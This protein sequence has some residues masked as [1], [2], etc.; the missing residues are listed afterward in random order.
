M[1]RQA[2]TFFR[3]SRPVVAAAAVLSLL[4]TGMVTMAA[5][6]ADEG[7][8]PAATD[9]ALIASP[10]TERAAPL[11]PVGRFGPSDSDRSR[12]TKVAESVEKRSATSDE[13]LNSDGTRSITT[14]ALP[15]YYQAAGSEAWS[16]IDTVLVADETRTGWV[17]SNANRWT[18][19]FAAAGPEV[20]TQRVEVDG[21]AISFAPIGANEQAT[22]A[23]DG[24]AVTYDD[25]WRETDAV[26][27]VKPTGTDERLVLKSAD[28]PTSFAFAV[29]GATPRANEGGGVDLTVGR[30][31]IAAVPPLTVETSRGLVRASKAGAA[32]AVKAVGDN[33]GEITISISPDW[34]KDLPADAFPVV[35]DPSVEPVGYGTDWASANN[36][37]PPGTQ[38]S[39]LRVGN[40]FGTKWRAR[41]KIAVPDPSV[42][43][44]GGTQP[45]YLTRAHLHA[46]V[47]GFAYNEFQVYAHTSQPAT[48]FAA[49]AAGAPQTTYADLVGRHEA[50]V[51]DWV[52]LRPPGS[53]A[54]YGFKGNETFENTLETLSNPR[55]EYT[56]VQSPDPTWLVSPVG[57]ISTT[58][59]LLSADPRPHASTPFVDYDFKVT[60]DAFGSGTVVDSGWV[61]QPTWQVPAGALA[62]GITYYVTVRVGINDPWNPDGEHYVPPAAPTQTKTITVKQRL[63]AGG[64]TPTDTVG[65]VPGATQTPSKGAPSPGAAPASVTVNMVTGNLALSVNTHQLSTVSGPAGASLNYDSLGTT[66]LNGSQRGL[67]GRYSFNGAVIGQR[68]D[69][70]IDFNWPGSPMGGY[71]PSSSY[72]FSAEWIGNVTVPASG[73][74]RLGGSVVSGTMTVY[75]DGSPTPYVTLGAGATPTFGAATGWSPGSQHALR[76][77]YSTSGSRVGRLWARNTTPPS[78]TAADVVV[79]TDWLTP[80]VTGL[81][82]GWRLS[83]NPYSGSWTRIEDLGGQAV[84]QSSTG[85]TVTFTRRVDG[86]YQS[87]AGVHDSLTAAMATRPGQFSMGEFRL[88]TADNFL[89]TFG[90]DGWVRKVESITD[91]RKPAA[92]A[93]EYETQLGVVG[94]PVLKTITDPVTTRAITLCYGGEAA[95]DSSGSNAP[96]GMLG[97][98]T[99]WDGAAGSSY[100]TLVY[101]SGRLV[102]VINPGNLVADFGY[103][104][105]GRLNQIRDPLAN[106]VIAQGLISTCPSSN[107]GTD[108]ST[109][110]TYDS[111]A[112]VATVAQPAPHGFPVSTRPS[113]SYTY[114]TGLKRTSVSVAGFNPSLGY[115]S[116]AEYDG[117][118]R[119][120]KQW[121]AEGRL[122]ETKWDPNIDRP[123]T[124]IDAFGL[125]TTDI[126]GTANLLTDRWGPAPTSC[127]STTAPYAPNGSCTVAVTQHE[128]DE[129]ID[130]LAATFW[131]NPNQTGPAKLHLTGPG[132]TGPSGPGCPT[133][134]LCTQWNTPPVTPAGGACTGC[135]W[136]NDYFAWS[137]RLTGT[138]SVPANTQ[139]YVF[140]TQYVTVSSNGV[141]LANHD[142]ANHDDGY[143]TWGGSG[144][145]SP[146]LTGTIPIQIDFYGGATGINGFFIWANQGGNPWIPNQW[147]SPGYGLETTSIDPDN[148][149][150]TTSYTD[151]ATGIGPEFG[152][153]T[154]V[155]ADPN[156][157]ALTTRTTYE[158][159]GT[160]HWLRKTASTLPAGNATT[161]VNY[162]GKPGV[163]DCTGDQQAGAWATACGVTVGDAQHGL[164]AEQ[165]DPA[166]SGGQGRRQQFLYDKAGRAVGRRVGPANTIGARPWQCT[167]FD[168]R[169][170]PTS[171]TYPSADGA[172]ARTVTYGYAVGGDPRVAS[173]TDP[174]GTVTASVD[175]L[176]RVVDYTDVWGTY[177]AYYYDQAGRST[178]V[179]EPYGNMVNTYDPNTGRLTAVAASG[180]VANLAY[181]TN[182]LLNTVT[183]TAPGGHQSRLTAGY[184]ALFRQNSAT[185]ANLD[186]T[187]PARI[188]GQTVTYSL[189]GRKTN[190]TLE[191]GAANPIEPNASGDDFVYDGAGRV[192]TAH[193]VNGRFDYSYAINPGADGC[194]FSGGGANSNRTAV[195]FVPTSGTTTV[196]RSCYNTADQL[197]R[198]IDAAGPSTGYAYD[199]RGNQ[200]SNPGTAYD[201][202]AADRLASA[203]GNDMTAIYTRDALDRLVARN[204]T[205]DTVRYA[206]AGFTDTPAAILNTT[207]AVVERHLA[208]PGGV[209]T[210]TTPASGNTTWSFPDMAGNIVTTTTNSGTRSSGPATYDPWGAAHTGGI[211]NTATATK[212]A[213]FGT[214]GKLTDGE[215]GGHTII[216]M[217]ARPYNPTQARF[218]AVDPIAGGC[219][220]NYVYVYGDPINMSDLSGKF[221]IPSLSF[222]LGDLWDATGGKIVSAA[223]SAHKALCGNS[224]VRELTNYVGVAGKGH[225]SSLSNTAVKA[226]VTATTQGTIRFMNSLTKGIGFFESTPLLRAVT[227]VNIAS[228]AVATG[229]NLSCRAYD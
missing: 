6:A 220:N 145:P 24:S 64:P 95:C 94:A 173:V 187:G 14:Y 215:A 143:G 128:Y 92:L 76:V 121:D 100:S 52:A 38:S 16:P 84:L 50:D 17:H 31:M 36:A 122:T 51:T 26:Y 179:S 144:N 9:V 170:R 18:A 154:A 46:D 219:A 137:M 81:P 202:D 189:A 156:G 205:S 89:F 169:G 177:T 136:P 39:V 176:G 157:V 131:P 210:T 78:G 182:G 199:A 25:L 141:Q 54:W 66:G 70:S 58:T 151:T 229:F 167:T 198:T 113:R 159:P 147:L 104:A 190:A 15:R 73:T 12:V 214:A 60:T 212:H 163:T 139:L 44:P 129:G 3:R 56:F 20:G 196:T 110:V 194:G 135:Y 204:N 181:N 161:Y 209:R 90:A 45:W 65:S 172:P 59:P 117:Q 88:A 4:S 98:I 55:I 203:T 34:L 29:S 48:T 148:K 5:Q 227:K 115:A 158:T 30:K 99:Y 71:A 120:I 106:D 80:R 97:R 75:V 193:V 32:F 134:T 42:L 61:P 109:I 41:T 152:L 127:F 166:P 67:Y 149:I 96:A 57:T 1:R 186:G 74:W 164:L 228:I 206:Y 223:A 184:D 101:D 69:P 146:P 133:N 200:T 37:I 116:R 207:N 79:P 175:L 111:S 155:T 35:I 85:A 224:F 174:G 226:T 91:D 27:L 87:P 19:S 53:D 28:A 126:Y 83:S 77:T 218:L 160:G 130:A 211:T 102:R 195:T 124:T 108:C 22:R 192:S 63:G 112:R 191:T 13:W 217:G 142:A 119:I 153:P 140:S 62:D 185:F 23:T 49:I 178:E 216:H 183:Y 68:L 105:S 125:Q 21:Y 201:W 171:Q 221:G 180:I 43:S 107:P 10:E 188:A 225:H 8:E 222:S 11:A 47:S 138:I 93:Y 2:G 114:D 168:S 162:C 123:L 165:T 197:V 40:D 213:A 132:G 150:V 82:A 86:T 72:P 208:W 7:R 103:D 118:G 33:A